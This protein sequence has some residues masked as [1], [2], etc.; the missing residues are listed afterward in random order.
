MTIKGANLA[1]LNFS[2]I[3]HVNDTCMYQVIKYLLDDILDPKSHHIELHVSLT[4]MQLFLQ[5]ST[6]VHA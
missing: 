1:I 4:V 5:L 2:E 6:A 3:M